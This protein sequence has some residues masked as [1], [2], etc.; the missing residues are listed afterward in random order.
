MWEYP[1]LIQ[2]AATF[3]FSLPGGHQDVSGQRA[4]ASVFALSAFPD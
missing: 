4:K 3:C 2:E 1:C